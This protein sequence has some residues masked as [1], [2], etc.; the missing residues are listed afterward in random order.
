MY[1]EFWQVWQMQA[2]IYKHTAFF[3]SQLPLLLSTFCPTLVYL[4]QNFRTCSDRLKLLSLCSLLSEQLPEKK[5]VLKALLVGKTW[6]WRIIRQEITFC[7][8]ICLRTSS[9]TIYRIG[10]REK[11]S[12]K[13]TTRKKQPLHKILRPCLIYAGLKFPFRKIE[14]LGKLG[15]ENCNGKKLNPLSYNRLLEELPFL[16]EK[17]YVHSLQYFLSS[18]AEL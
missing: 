2:Y 11:K 15:N 8:M 12:V 13:K 5:D 17:R 18:V 6:F 1:L 3:V 7:V 4:L 9:G 14:N 10:K 16:I